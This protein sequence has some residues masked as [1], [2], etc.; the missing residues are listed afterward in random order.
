MAV[1]Y[2]VIVIGAGQNGLVAAAYLAKAGRR[3]LVLESREVIGGTH[4]TEE[5]HR[6]FRVDTAF[7]RAGWLDESIATDLGLGNSSLERLAADPAVFVPLGDGGFALPW[8]PAAAATEI[9]KHSPS[10]AG[11]W[12]DFSRLVRKLSGFLEHVYGAAA[13]QLTS[14]RVVDLLAL[15]GLGRRVR[16]MG[17]TDMI[18]LLRIL[19][20]SVAELLDD[21]FETDVLKG[22]I[23][24]GGITGIFQGPRS[25]G[26]AFVMLHHQ[27][28][29][30]EGAFRSGGLLRGGGGA[31]AASLL[32]AATGFGAEIRTGAAVVKVRIK[33]GEATGV[34]LGSGGEIAAKQV[35]S[36]VDPRRT[37]LGLVEPIELEP[38][39][40]RAVQNIKYRGIV[41]KVNLALGEL[42]RFSGANGDDRLLRGVIS[43]S[44][45]LDYL[46]RAYDDAK[47]GGVSRAPYLE[48]V[49]PSLEDP[50]LAP[51][52]KHV[53]SVWMQYAPYHLKQGTWDA[54][55]REALG[56]RIIESLGALAPNLPASIIHRQVLTPLDLET[57]YGV[58]E[59]N[60]Y[61][62]EQTLDQ[63]LFMRP[64]PGW[65]H[66]RTPIGGLFLGGSGNHPGPGIVGGAGRLAV[67][68]MLKT[69]NGKR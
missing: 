12:E 47:H 42:P 31:L 18:E 56:D 60:L 25:A 57:T 2:D 64:V 54:A 41:A 67:R 13:P 8:S 14:T 23:G 69:V 11:K 27:V 6:G 63:I 5:I 1:S 4:A 46:E 35:L 65:A 19:P 20:M 9:R 22:A 61:H 3:V 17:K 32:K 40:T 43:L 28:G 58:T 53:M 34:M 7:H 62:G 10:D 36:T 30:R 52:G 51:A 29:A 50:S 68:E 16:G 21:W 66:Y 49:I 59:G 15:L 33:N 26:T 55:A 39:F 24:A 48:A 44:P 45:S 37:L 38:E